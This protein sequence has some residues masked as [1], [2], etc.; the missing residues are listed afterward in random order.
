MYHLLRMLLCVICR[1]LQSFLMKEE[2][3]SK[4]M[5]LIAS[6]FIFGTENHF[7]D[8]TGQGQ[9]QPTVWSLPL[10]I[11]WGR[12]HSFLGEQKRIGVSL[13]ASQIK[14]AKTQEQ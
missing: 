3:K 1:S 13:I 11:I 5:R 9:E 14:S 7:P 4:Q 12:R 10:G 8:S 6:D 2:P